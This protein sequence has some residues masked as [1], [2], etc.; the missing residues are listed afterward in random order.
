MKGQAPERSPPDASFTWPRAMWTVIMAVLMY[1]LYC[2]QDYHILSEEQ[3]MLLIFLAVPI[4]AFAL[5]GAGQ[6]RADR[7]EEGRAG[8]DKRDG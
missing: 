7:G 2:L 8:K 5:S 6:V 1:G 3:I 4:A